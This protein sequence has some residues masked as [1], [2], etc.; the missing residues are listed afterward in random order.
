MGAIFG[1]FFCRG[2]ST[3]QFQ[4]KM[5]SRL[6]HRYS[7]INELYCSNNEFMVAASWDE[8]D[9]GLLHMNGCVVAFE[10]EIY[11]TLDLYNRFFSEKQWD[12]KENINVLLIL[13]YKKFGLDFPSYLNGVFSIALWDTELH[14]LVLCRDHVGSHSLFYS[15]TNQGVFFASTVN[16]I[17]ATGVVPRDISQIAVNQYFA[18]KAL[19]PPVTMYKFVSAVRPSHSVLID[20]RNKREYDYW[21][22]HEIDVDNNLKEDV[23]IDQ[24]RHIILNAIDIRAEYSSAFGSIV[25]GGL[26]TGIV[27]ARLASK[28][29]SHNL[30]VFS[31][32]FD[33]DSYSDDPLQ[34]LMVRKFSLNHHQAVLGPSEFARILMEAVGELDSPLNDIAFVGMAKVFELAREH[35]FRI[36]FEGEG[37]DEIFPAGNSQGERQIAKFLLIPDFIRHK[38]IGSLFHT[39]PLG[40]SIC[41]KTARILVRIGMDDNERRLTWRTYFHNRLRQ[42]LLISDWYRDEDPYEIQRNYLMQCK[43]ADFINKYQFGLI[44][45]F[46]PDNLLF[47]DE[48]MAAREGIMNRIPLIDRRLVELSLKIPSKLQLAKPGRLSDGIKLLYKK[49][50]TGYVPDQIIKHKKVRGFSHPTSL[51]FRNELKEFLIDI[52]LGETTKNRG[53]FKMQYVKKLVDNHI[54]GKSDYDYPLNALLIFELWMRK[55]YDSLSSYSL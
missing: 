33:E 27:T 54:A 16:A 31:I 9:A 26:D 40:D 1:A 46:L 42:K 53:I 49:A 51:W 5:G 52:L 20:E 19:S 4:N 28:Y 11:N 3:V 24:L 36:M 32:S 2:V 6:A 45:T 34:Q 8:R 15:I 44:K 38:I 22:L 47:K 14:Q 37:P 39:M 30:D 17:L 18:S 10:G 35:G 25:S 7:F 29:A 23:C 41:C 48:R 43:N 21:R 55:N 50:L 13:M 12:D